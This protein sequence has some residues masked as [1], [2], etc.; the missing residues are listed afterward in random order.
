MK[1]ERHN[2]CAHICMGQERQSRFLDKLPLKGVHLF[3]LGDLFFERIHCTKL[4]VALS[5]WAKWGRMDQKSKKNQN[6]KEKQN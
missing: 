4:V 1:K 5:W 2:I 6:K 3:W